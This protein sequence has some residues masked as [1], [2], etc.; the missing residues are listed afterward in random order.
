MVI[1]CIYKHPKVPVTEFSEDYLVPLLDKLTKEINE[2]ILM[3]M[4]QH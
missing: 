3:G 2:K 1:G 4:F